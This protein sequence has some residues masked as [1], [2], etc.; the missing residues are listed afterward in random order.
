MSDFL[1][2][3]RNPRPGASLSPDEMQRSLQKWRDW[4]QGL[5]KSGTLKGGEP[6]EGGGKVVSGTRALVTDGPFAEKEV[7]SGYLIISA[8]NLED[9]TEISKGCPIFAEGGSVEVRPVR[10][11]QGG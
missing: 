10:P 11:M 3:F 8:K 6:L 7:V 2:L 5:A 9:A 4:M 1:F